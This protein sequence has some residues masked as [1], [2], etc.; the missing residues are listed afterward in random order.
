MAE[1]CSAN[2]VHSKVGT[3]S[4]AV[5]KSRSRTVC[6]SSAIVFG[7]AHAG[8]RGGAIVLR[9]DGEIDELLGDRGGE[10]ARRGGGQGRPQIRGIRKVTA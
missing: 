6:R 1:L 10:I 3:P 4:D 7:V 9:S 5:V 8:S 2:G